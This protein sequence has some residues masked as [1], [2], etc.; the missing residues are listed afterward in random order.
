VKPFF[1]KALIRPLR[2]N[3]GAGRSELAPLLLE[4]VESLLHS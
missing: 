4:V 1:E 2:S 3:I